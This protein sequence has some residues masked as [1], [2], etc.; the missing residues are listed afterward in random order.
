MQAR[1][2]KKA[3]ERASKEAKETQKREA[4]AAELA[5]KEQ[6]KR[7]AVEAR[8][9]REAEIVAREQAKREAEQVKHVEKCLRQM[10]RTRED[11]DAGKIDTTEAIQR[12]RDIAESI[13]G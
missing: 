7:D 2:N 10:E 11:L 3:E 1:K 9:A 13:S 4:K 12:L 8:K 6:A 5:A